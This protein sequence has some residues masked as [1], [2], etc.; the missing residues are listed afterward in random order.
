MTLGCMVFS[1]ECS[2]ASPLGAILTHK[3]SIGQATTFVN[4][5]KHLRQSVTQLKG[6]FRDHRL[7]PHTSNSL[8]RQIN[9]HANATGAAMQNDK[10]RRAIT[11]TEQSP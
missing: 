11:S 2:V 6:S 10:A 9:A 3:S 7:S 4:H 5:S 1:P 8:S